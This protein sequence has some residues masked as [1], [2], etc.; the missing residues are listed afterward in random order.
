MSQISNM[1]LLQFAIDNGML[2]IN[3]I[4]AQV[5]MKERKKYLEK[6]N[7]DIYRS[8]DGYWNTYFDSDNDSG[9][10]RIKRR[11]KEDLEEAIYLHYRSV[12]QE[13]TI[14]AIFEQWVDEKLEYGEIRKQTY[15][16]YKTDF[17]RFF[18]KN[19]FY[20]GFAVRKIRYVSEEELEEFIKITI[21]KMQLTQKAYT[22]L[23]TLVNGIFKYAKKKKYTTLS[24]TQFM[25]DID[26]SKRSFKA[27]VKNKEDEVYT[28]KEAEKLTDHLS[29]QVDDLRALGLLLSFYCGLRVG[30]LSS[31]KPED[32][33]EHHIHVRRTE[34]KVKT[35]E[36]STLLVQEYTKSEAGDRLVILTDNAKEILE[37]IMKIRKPGE[38][39]FMDNG[40]R[41]RSNGFRRKLMRVCKDINIPYRSN[42]KIRRTYGTTLIDAGVDDAIVAEQMG[43]TDINTTRKYYYFGNKSE[44]RKM[45]QIRAAIPW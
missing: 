45:E 39:L 43:H 36:G 10:K 6:H 14:K 19:E 22:G 12:D 16:R 20:K 25:G 7:H 40:K 21:V 3:S 2:D 37:L 42:H 15:D 4:H 35:S 26:I 44:A 29:K 27:K 24:I 11:N 33:S 1:E 38:Y 8:K 34:V 41:I 13:P 17:I 30:E 31:L 32:C 18:V 5:Q 9:R 28:D 23:R